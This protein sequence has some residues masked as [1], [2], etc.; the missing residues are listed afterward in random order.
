M[1]SRRYGPL[2]HESLK[3]NRPD[4]IRELER[5]GE[6]FR[7][8]REAARSTEELHDQIAFQLS[9]NHPF[10]KTEFETIDQWKSWLNQVASELVIRE[11]ILVPD[12]ETEEARL[13]GYLD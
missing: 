11:R 4:V 13:H 2:H 9:Q 5:N 10:S 3:Q 6:S 1:T 12:Q 7:H 8:F